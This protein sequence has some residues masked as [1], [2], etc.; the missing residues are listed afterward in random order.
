MSNPS[1][2]HFL[3]QLESWMDGERSPAA[4]A[5]L[6]GLVDD[7]HAA[8]AQLTQDFVAWQHRRR[9]SFGQV[10]DGAGQPIRF[11]VRIDGVVV[12][13]L[14]DFGPAL[15]V[16]K[17]E[18]DQLAGESGPRSLLNAVEIIADQRAVA[19]LAGSLETIAHLIEALGHG[20]RQGQG[21]DVGARE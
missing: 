20:Q 5:H 15:A 18:Q 2:T 1:C 14:R 16:V 4:Q 9:G 21:R 10:R 8:P 11:P 7:A 13:D 17:V 6:N 3:A 12:G 19:A